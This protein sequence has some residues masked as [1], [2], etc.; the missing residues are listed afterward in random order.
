MVS[1]DLKI[2]PPVVAVLVAGAMYAATLLPPL[3]A[4]HSSVR[5]AI[6]LVL[7]V[8]GL[9]FDLA[10]LLAFRKA[11]TTTNPLTPQRSSSV[12]TGGVYRLTRNPMYLGLALLLLALAVFLASPW[13]LLG[14]FVFAAFITR[15]QIQPEERALAQRFGAPYLDYCARVR[16]WW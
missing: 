8:L 9:C 16:R 5:V 13:A 12:V 14:P 7:A 10:G 2:P 11:K 6:A 3:L 15:F 4:L 1:L